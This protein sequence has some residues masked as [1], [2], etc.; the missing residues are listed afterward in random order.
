[1]INIVSNVFVC[2]LFYSIFKKEIIAIDYNKNKK[3]IVYCN[4]IVNFFLKTQMQK[5]LVYK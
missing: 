5:W 3:N 1:M 4:A 2:F